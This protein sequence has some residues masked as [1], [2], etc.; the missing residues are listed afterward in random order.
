[1]MRRRF[2]LLG[3]ALALGAL[4]GAEAQSVGRML[5]SDFSGAAGDVWSV[6]T[7]PFRTS[8][9]R[10]W[11]PF[12][13]AIAGSAMLLPWDD[14]FDRY[15]A[16]HG[17]DA[18]WRSLAELREGGH[19][20]SGRT[21]TPVAIAVYGVGLAIKNQNLRDG[22]MGCVASYASESVLRN[23][24]FYPLVARPRPDP[25]RTHADDN[26]P[27]GAE[28]GDQYVFQVP[29]SGTWGKHS[30]PAGHIANVAACV[31]FLTSRFHMGLVEPA[32]YAVAAGVGV[33]RMAD[34]RHWA[35]DTML[36]FI[37]GYAVGRNTAIR[38]ERRLKNAQSA[39]PTTDHGLLL[40]PGPAVVNVG[41]EWIF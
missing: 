9:G 7:A 13:V 4:E 40:R 30:M 25:D 19:A 17:Q 27:G 16:V 14:D 20:F 12:V 36:G 37:F 32:L 2:W 39:V 1:M 38:S 21:V 33:G 8:Q 35:S 26:T 41:W 18:A 22:V 5:A 31:S 10:D 15:F 6:W 29:G 24:V 3:G 34:R 23:Y 28:E 11:G